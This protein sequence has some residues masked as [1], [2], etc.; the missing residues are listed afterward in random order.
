MILRILLIYVPVMAI[1]GRC[2]FL[3]IR[4]YNVSYLIDI[5]FFLFRQIEF[6]KATLTE[7]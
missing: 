6:K 5:I 7:M 1:R 3:I 4:S 2:L